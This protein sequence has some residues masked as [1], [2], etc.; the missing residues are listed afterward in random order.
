MTS[1]NNP[2]IR[3]DIFNNNYN[4]S[5]NKLSDNE[6]Y[7]SDIE[8][9]NLLNMFKEFELLKNNIG[10]NKSLN[11]ITNH[12]S[13]PEWF[14][15]ENIKVRLYN[16]GLYYAAVNNQINGTIIIT[17]T[18]SGNNTSVYYY[19]LV[20]LTEKNIF[21]NAESKC[22]IEVFDEFNDLYYKITYINGRSNGILFDLPTQTNIYNK[23]L[24]IERII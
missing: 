2:N 16:Y 14:I 8:K 12:V 13:N 7:L 5:S 17:V 24:L 18:G 3:S 21:I 4:K 22:I 20:T 9:Y 11:K 10:G 1:Y 6:N 23:L 19:K 15:Y